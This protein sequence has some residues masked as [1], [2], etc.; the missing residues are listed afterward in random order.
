MKTHVSQNKSR[1]GQFNE[2]IALLI[3]ILAVVKSQ[4]V[5]NLSH[6]MAHFFIEN[7]YCGTPSDKY[8]CKKNSALKSFLGNADKFILKQM[9]I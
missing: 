3:L 9:D 2:K 8:K 5:F 4:S 1:Y 6:A 7:I